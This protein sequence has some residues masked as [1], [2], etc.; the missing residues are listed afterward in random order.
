MTNEQ[1]VA[2]IQ[3]IKK[4]LKDF[5]R[6][7][8]DQSVFMPNSIKA[9]FIGDGVRIIRAGDS[10][11]LPLVGELK[12]AIYFEEDTNKLKVYNATEQAWKE[13]TLT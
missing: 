4:R 12:G 8:L 6:G 9:R 10:D 13:E 1:I 2:E 5:E 7:R 11:N 3:D